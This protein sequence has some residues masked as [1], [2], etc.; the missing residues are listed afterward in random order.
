MSN[1]PNL[2]LRKIDSKAEKFNQKQNYEDNF[3]K[4]DAFA[5]TVSSQLADIEQKVDVDIP[6][7]LNEKANKVQEAWITPTLLNG[8][9]AVNGTPQFMKDSLGFVHFRGGL[10]GAN[11]AGLTAFTMPT[12]YRPSTDIVFSDIKATSY[13]LVNSFGSVII[14]NEKCW[15]ALSQLSYLAEV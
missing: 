3:D 10:N 12:G 9:V 8:W 5:G 13:V 2:G 6:A 7:Q 14:D 15:I 1:T 4:I 11:S